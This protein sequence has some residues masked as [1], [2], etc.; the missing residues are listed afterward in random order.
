MNH[1]LITWGATPMEA[2]ERHMEIV[3]KAEKF[4]GGGQTIVSVQSETSG[5]ACSPRLRGALCR[6]RKVV[7]EFDGSPEVLEFLARDDA[8][9]I[10]Q[11]GPATPDHL[12]YTKRFPLFLDHDSVE[13]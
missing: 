4:V 9:K 11:I 5:I 2:Y 7:L 8:E 12:L 1:G 3:G 6:D 13:K 10:T